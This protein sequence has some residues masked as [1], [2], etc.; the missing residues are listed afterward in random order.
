MAKQMIEQTDECAFEKG[1]LGQ[2]KEHA[3]RMPAEHDLAV[4]ESLGLK[5]ISIRLPESLIQD[6]KFIA[7]REGLGYQ[8]LIRRVLQR[9][10]TM[11]FKNMAREAFGTLSKIEAAQAMPEE[12]VADEAVEP[13]RKRA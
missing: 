13:A 4:D 2:S 1:E 5:L 10:T 7:N 8:P 9:F 11:E 3:V 12:V 6:L